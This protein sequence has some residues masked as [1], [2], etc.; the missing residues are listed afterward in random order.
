MFVMLY[1][2]RHARHLCDLAVRVVK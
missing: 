2:F 1:S